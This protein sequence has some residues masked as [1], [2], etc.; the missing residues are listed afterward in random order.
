MSFNPEKPYNEL[1][2]LPPKAEV[3]TRT[4][5]KQVIK[6][7][8]AL[9]E[10]NGKALIIPNQD[11]LI[12]NITLQ[13]AKDSSEIENVFTTSDNLFRAFSANM[14]NTDPA[15]KEV[16]SYR[17]ALWAAHTE[18]QE[19]KKFT[20]ALFIKIAQQLK[21]SDTAIRNEPGTKVQS[22][23]SGE[24]VYTPP[25][26][27]AV[28]RGK[29]KNL[30]TFLNDDSFSD[31]DPLVKMA[32]AHYQFEAIHPF[33]DGNGRTG[34]I[35][36]V[37]FLASKGLLD[38]PVLYLSSYIIRKKAAYYFLLRGVTEK[39]DWESWVLYMLQGVEETALQTIDRIVEIRQLMD[40]T[41]EK[42][43]QEL[44]IIYSKELVET[45][46]EKPYTKIESLVSKDIAVRQTAS[47]YL[48]DL[49]EIGVLKSQKCGKETVYLNTELVK[50]LSKQ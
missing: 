34:R 20:T 11:I 5:L 30:E 15:T 46:F 28:I 16:L 19:S 43:K 35:I 29:L 9:A 3:E 26:G 7:R 18:L 33:F 8:A 6:S 21:E 45:L 13:E 31:F 50:L 42:V 37:L 47:K 38:L 41:C 14:K 24:T 49:E 27:E 40:V 39:N 17:E 25:E 12:N 2:L 36:N 44:P 10:L 1:P 48:K 22:R 4:I 23:K 32:V